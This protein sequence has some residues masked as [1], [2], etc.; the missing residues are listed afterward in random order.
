MLLL[1]SLECSDILSNS[2]EASIIGL[3][4]CVTIADHLEQFRGS[5][6]RTSVF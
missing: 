6:Y 3:V 2:S 4:F 5:Y 1:G